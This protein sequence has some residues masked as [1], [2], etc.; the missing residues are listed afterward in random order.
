MGVRARRRR[1]LQ[2]PTTSSHTRWTHEWVRLGSLARSAYQSEDYDLVADAHDEGHVVLYDEYAETH[3]AGQPSIALASSIV[4]VEL[5]P[6]AGSSRSRID[7]PRAT[8]R[9]IAT[10]RRSPV[11]DPYTEVVD[12]PPVPRRRA[13]CR[14]RSPLRAAWMKSVT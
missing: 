8:E 2:V 11:T 13:S 7:G 10:S 9:A 5:S 12:Q 14:V 4:S 1:T 6:A 3:L